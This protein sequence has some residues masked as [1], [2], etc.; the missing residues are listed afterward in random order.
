MTT[1]LAQLAIGATLALAVVAA[2][3]GDDSTSGSA[4]EARRT[5]SQATLDEIVVLWDD[6]SQVGTEEEVAAAIAAHA[7]EEAVIYDTAFP[8]DTPYAEAFYSTLYGGVMD[9]MLDVTHSWLSEDGSQG[10]VLWLWSGTNIEG[11]SFELAGIS[12]IDFDEDGKVAYEYV[13]YPYDPSFVRE[14]IMGVGT[15]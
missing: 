3:G 14:A 15:E 2:C 9:A 8:G 6:P 10:G 1:H 12:L 7:T 4:D 5:N 11:N 13:T